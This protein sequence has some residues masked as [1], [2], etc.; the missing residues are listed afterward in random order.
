MKFCNVGIIIQA[1]TGSDRFP[2]KVLAS[3]EKKPNDLAYCQ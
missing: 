2:K 3:I 1:R